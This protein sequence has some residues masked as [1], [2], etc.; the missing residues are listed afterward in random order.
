MG[1]RLLR[2]LLGLGRG[3]S[4]VVGAAILLAVMVLAA[5]FY[6]TA[7]DKLV[8]ASQQA[9]KRVGEA[10]ST[11]ATLSS[12]KALWS[13]NGSHITIYIE[14]QAPKTLLVVAIAVVYTDGS[15][16]VW[17]KA[18]ST[19]IALPLAVAPATSTT[20]AIDTGGKTPA[21]ASLAVE[22]SPVVAVVAAKRQDQAPT[23]RAITI[24][25]VAPGATTWLGKAAIPTTKNATTT[26]NYPQQLTSTPLNSTITRISRSTITYT[27]FEV[28]DVPVPGWTNYGG[29]WSITTGFKGRALQ[30]TDQED[31]GLGGAVEYYYNN[32]LDTYTSLWVSVKTKLV[33]GAGRPL[34]RED[35]YGIALINS[36]LTRLYAIVIRDRARA[37]AEVV[38]RS[39]NVERGGWN[40]LSTAPM[41]SYSRGSWYV[42]VVNYTVTTTAVN[43]YVWVYDTSG[44]QLAYL[45]ASSTHINRFTPAYIGVIVDDLTAAFDDFIIATADPRYITVSGLPG[46]GYTITIIDD[47]GNTVST[48]TST[49][50]TATIN[51]VSDIVVGTGVDGRIEVYDA[52]GSLVAMYTASDCILG[53]DAYTLAAVYYGATFSD[54][55]SFSRVVQLFSANVSVSLATNANVTLRVY[56]NGS[57]ILCKNIAGSDSI[58]ASVPSNLLGGARVFNVTLVFNSTQP[59]S[60][61]MNWLGVL[62][63]GYF[64]DY[65]TDSL[66]LGS[67]TAI[68]FYN[69]T[70]LLLSNVTSLTA[71]YSVPAY[72]QFSGSAAI[73]YNSSSYV[74]Y[75]VNGSGVY[76][77]NPLGW[78]L[79]TSS[80][81]AVG[82]GARVEVV[83][84]FVVV[85]PGE[86]SGYAC[87]YDVS[88]GVAYNISLATYRLYRYT[89]SAV[90]NTAVVFT[91]LDSMGRVALLS[92]N[93]STNSTRRLAVLPMSCA[94][95][96]AVS[97]SRAYIV[98]CGVWRGAIGV[99]GSGAAVWIYDAKARASGLVLVTNNSTVQ[100]MGC[101]DRVEIYKDMLIA[102]DT[103]NILTIDRASK[104]V[105]EKSVTIYG[106]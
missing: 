84:R 50:A 72:T 33:G 92:L 12:V 16:S 66:L 23:T 65:V 52:R 24:E 93:L 91:A 101:C 71:L 26:K 97:S 85:L 22:A 9:M 87:V 13:F 83:G 41:A 48:V 27:D 8:T 2:G 53:G 62:G 96:L 11:T 81:R 88:R 103:Q 1:V 82:S 17:D 105:V 21:T 94:T 4:T 77:W 68:R 45:T 78:S 38:V 28:E 51:V 54:V 55:A 95:G 89:A 20:I 14:N 69:A 98:L 60:V 5:A 86:P 31:D 19:S 59:F 73:A 106:T 37:R 44:G 63:S 64:E 3:I 104:L 7:L 18:N 6:I 43:F 29:S 70:K 74:L 47:Q 40:D 80:C 32:R 57:Q 56:V 39:F 100:L 76:F 58:S 15:H 90:N 67:G 36:D 42:I 61:T 49:G 79:K 10:A 99:E 25:P 75:M 102:V 35:R 30:G 46:A 34:G